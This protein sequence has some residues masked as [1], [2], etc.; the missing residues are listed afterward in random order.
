[1]AG[2]FH[3]GTKLRLAVALIREESV[4]Q[5]CWRVKPSRHLAAE[6]QSIA[7]RET[8]SLSRTVR[9]L[10]GE[11]VEARRRWATQSPLPPTYDQV[12]SIERRNS[13]RL[14]MPEGMRATIKALAAADDRPMATMTIILLAEALRDRGVSLDERAA[15]EPI[16]TITAN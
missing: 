3:L 2:Y 9:R 1:M 5:T 10:V 15:T 13:L 14:R 6:V 16:G 4:M 8:R 11:A 12:E 7:D